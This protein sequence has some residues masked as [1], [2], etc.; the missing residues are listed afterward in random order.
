MKFGTRGV[1]EHIW[2]IFGLVSF[3]VIWGA[4]GALTIFGKYDFQ[5]AA[6]SILRILLQTNFLQLLLLTVHKRCFWEF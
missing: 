1:T 5:N 6:S 3:K 4:F 2:G